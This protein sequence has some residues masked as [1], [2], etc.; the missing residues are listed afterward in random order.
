MGLLDEFFLFARAISK[1][2]VKEIMNDD[3]LAVKSLD[4]SITIGSLIRDC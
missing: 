1:E 3:F 2:E 4:K